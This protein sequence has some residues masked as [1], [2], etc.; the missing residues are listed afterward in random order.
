M[1]EFITPGGGGGSGGGAAGAVGVGTSDPDDIAA[2]FAQ[3]L[4]SA[5]SEKR[6]GFQAGSY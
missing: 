5:D 4:Q 1:S 3:F 2:A 6:F